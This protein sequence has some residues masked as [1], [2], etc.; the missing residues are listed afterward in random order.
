MAQRYIHGERTV[1]GVFNPLIE[2]SLREGTLVTLIN[3]TLPRDSA[4]IF[5]RQAGIVLESMQRRNHNAQANQRWSRGW[6]LTFILSGA[7][8]TAVGCY[9]F[10]ALEEAPLYHDTNVRLI[11]GGSLVAAT[12]LLALF[13]KTKEE[14]EVQI[15]VQR[16]QEGRERVKAR[17]RIE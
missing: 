15:V 6:G 11:V 8:M 16:L 9:D 5:Y 4:E 13:G 1:L 17:Y 14:K 7:V 10:K 3:T 2:K 12:G